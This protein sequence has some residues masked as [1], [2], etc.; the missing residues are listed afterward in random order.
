MPSSSSMGTRADAGLGY[1]ADM[2]RSPLSSTSSVGAAPALGLGAGSTLQ[3]LGHN[4]S[5]VVVQD[6]S[7][8]AMASAYGLSVNNNGSLGTS[9]SLG[10]SSSYGYSSDSMSLGRVPSMTSMIDYDRQDSYDGYRTNQ[11]VERE[12]QDYRQTSSTYDLGTRLSSLGS[13]VASSTIPSVGSSRTSDT[14]VVNN[15]RIELG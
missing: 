1:G 15:V 9:A 14:I 10:G 4:S 6:Y 13:S 11:P 5:A 2:R 12:R 7:R 3:A 8:N